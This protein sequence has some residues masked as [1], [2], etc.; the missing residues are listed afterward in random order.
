MRVQRAVAAGL[1]VTGLMAAR[2]AAA[3]TYLTG[4]GGIVFGGDLASGEAQDLNLDN[5]HGVYGA[6]IGFIGTPLGLEVEFGYSPNF[7]GSDR[8]VIPKNNLATLMGNLVLSGHVG[9]SSR[10]YASAGAGLLKSRV[11]DADDF[12]D[13]DRNDFGVNVGAGVLVA[14]GESVA[15]RGDLRYFRNV[16]DPEPDDE[17]DIDFGSFDFWRATAGLALRF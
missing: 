4:W 12:F 1:L 9:E 3:E 7:F 2:P 5:R 16:G 13:V 11:D 15:L 6:A 10:I 14:V 17:F 8:D